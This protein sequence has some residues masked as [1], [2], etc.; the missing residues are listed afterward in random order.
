MST[1][2]CIRNGKNDNQTVLYDEKREVVIMSANMK[3]RATP[4]VQ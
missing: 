1:A 3:T 2:P 4:F